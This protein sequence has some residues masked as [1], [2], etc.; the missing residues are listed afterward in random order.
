MLSLHVKF[1]FP[2]GEP[3]R[4]CEGCFKTHALPGTGFETHFDRYGPDTAPAIIIIHS[5]GGNRQSVGSIVKEL[6]H[7]YR[8]IAPD[9]PGSGS[10]SKEKFTFD[11]A[12]KMVVDLIVTQALSSGG[13]FLIGHNLGAAVAA[14]V[15]SKHSPLCSGLVCIGLGAESATT[16]LISKATKLLPNSGIIGT[17]YSNDLF[18]SLKTYHGPKMVI[19]GTKEMKKLTA[20]QTNND[21]GKSNLKLE[22]VAPWDGNMEEIFKKIHDILWKFLAEVGW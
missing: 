14:E 6:S 19:G 4:V 18:K 17:N 10:R 12:V 5:E 15:A 11:A 9:M 13:A 22:I 21:L 3:Q 20:S 1:D 7:V 8:V 2:M 16:Q